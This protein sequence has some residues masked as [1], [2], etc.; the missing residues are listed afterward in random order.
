MSSHLFRHYRITELLSNGAR[1]EDVAAMVGT[2]PAEIHKTYHHWVKEYEDR[3]DE[4]QA[5]EF[6]KHGLDENGKK[7]D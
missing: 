4:A 3:L 5:K 6:A 2:S 7:K 1:V